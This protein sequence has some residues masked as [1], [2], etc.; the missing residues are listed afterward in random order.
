MSADAA[1]RKDSEITSMAVS[2]KPPTERLMTSTL[3]TTA[4][5]IA[6]TMSDR[7]QPPSSGFPVAQQTLY[8]A[9]FAAGAMPE[10]SPNSWPSTDI[11]TPWLPAAVPATWLPWPWPSRGERNS[12]SL[13]S[14]GGTLPANPSEK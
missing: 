5:S 1:E 6:A 10:P 7:K 13:R 3:S 4:W 2:W 12:S 9:I 14:S 11:S 8:E